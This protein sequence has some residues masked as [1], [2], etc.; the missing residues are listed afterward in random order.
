MNNTQPSYR[1][2]IAQAAWFHPLRRRQ[3]VTAQAQVLEYQFR[4]RW[5]PGMIVLW[6]N[7][8]TQQD[9]ANDYYPER[10]R[11]ERTAVVGDRPV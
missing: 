4:L 8:S 9:A 1:F 10:R 7:R 3:V 5:S 6:D 11:R 2:R